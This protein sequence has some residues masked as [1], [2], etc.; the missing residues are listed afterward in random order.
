MTYISGIARRRLHDTLL[1]PIALYQ[2]DGA[3]KLV[4]SSGN[5]R[6]LTEAVSTEEIVGYRHD[7]LCINSGRMESA[8]VAFQITAAVSVAALVRVVSFSGWQGIVGY[9][10]SGESLATNTIWN[11]SF[12][13]NKLRWYHEH[14]SGTDDIFD[15]TISAQPMVWQHI[16]ATRDA[17]G[18]GINLYINGENVG[19]GTVTAPSGGTSGTFFLMEFP[20]GTSPFDEAIQSVAVFDAELTPLQVRELARRTG[21]LPQG[22]G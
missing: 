1:A 9:G 13:G 3:N 16:C 15:S 8:D 12:I 17:L 14:G 10:G 20:G 2:L 7:L 21:I 6:S 5:G 22:L 11:L 4:D 19:S 18:T